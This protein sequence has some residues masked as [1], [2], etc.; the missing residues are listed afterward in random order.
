[1]TANIDKALNTSKKAHGVKMTSKGRLCVVTSHRRLYEVI[2]T[3]R[4][5]WGTSD[6]VCTC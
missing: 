5:R 4:A 6:S 3:L 1:M 2:L